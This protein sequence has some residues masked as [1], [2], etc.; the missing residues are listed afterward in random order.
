MGK[1]PIGPVA[2]SISRSA[3]LSALFRETDRVQRM[4]MPLS[5]MLRMIND[6]GHWEARLG[7]HKAT[8]ICC[9]PWL[10]GRARCCA[11]MT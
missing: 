8:I 9:G 11:A 2:V 7:A 3:L 10:R 1:D 6:F 5:L 4:R